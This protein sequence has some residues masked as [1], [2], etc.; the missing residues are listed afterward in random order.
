MAPNVCCRLSMTLNRREFLAGVAAAA[1][2][3]QRTIAQGSAIP[4]IDT[5]IHLYDP[6]RP[7][8]VPYPA[9]DAPT[10]LP[11]RYRSDVE[12]LG[13]TG[14]IKVEASPWVEDNLWVLDLI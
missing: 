3:P 14:A 1:A 2:V 5:H 11:D 12:P 6:T 10:A 9:P 8:G 7:Q 4:I 13:I